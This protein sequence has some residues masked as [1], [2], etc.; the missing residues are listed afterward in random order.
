MSPAA[1]ILAV[2]SIAEAGII[3]FLLY[4]MNKIMEAVDNYTTAVEPI[5][6]EE[7]FDD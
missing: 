6:M 2:V 7:T 1:I 4:T 3:C 5:E